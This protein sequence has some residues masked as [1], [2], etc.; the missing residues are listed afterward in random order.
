MGSSPGA[1]RV[2]PRV[3]W[4][5]CWSE[6]RRRHWPRSSVVTSWTRRPRSPRPAQA[7]TSRW[8]ADMRITT[9]DVLRTVTQTIDA[10][11]LPDTPAGWPA[12]YLRSAVMLLTYVEDRVRLE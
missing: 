3:R 10:N 9:E 5:C 1:T 8:R 2:R 4:A 6:I 11:V 12:S 7:N